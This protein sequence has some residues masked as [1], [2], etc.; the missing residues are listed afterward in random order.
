MAGKSKRKR[1]KRVNGELRTTAIALTRQSRHKR[2]GHSYKRG[3]GVNDPFNGVITKQ[4]G[5]TFE[6]DYKLYNKTRGQQGLNPKPDSRRDENITYLRRNS[7]FN[8]IRRVPIGELMERP[9]RS[10]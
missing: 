4:P 10:W 9:I 8:V 3:S 7:I 6:E 1:N 5:R 2:Y